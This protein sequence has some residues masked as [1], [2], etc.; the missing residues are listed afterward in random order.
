L[1]RSHS[2]KEGGAAPFSGHTEAV[3]RMERTL[4]LRRAADSQLAD[5]G[6]GE[7]PVCLVDEFDAVFN[8]FE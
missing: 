7:G 1:L 2:S 6:I 5:D 3:R 4:A 8:E